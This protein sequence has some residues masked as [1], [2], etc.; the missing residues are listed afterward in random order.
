[1]RPAARSIAALAG[2]AV[3]L[4]A[5]THGNSPSGSA[6]PTPPPTT[7]GDRV[8]L[9][10]FLLPELGRPNC[11]LQPA[12]P[13]RGSVLVYLVRQNFKIPRRDEFVAVRR[14]IRQSERK[15]PLRAALLELLNGPT[16]EERRMGCASIF[17][18]RSADLLRDVAIVDG[19]AV[20]NFRDLRS[21]V[22]GVGA[23][24]ASAVFLL[25]LNLTVLQFPT[26]E[27]IRYELG[28]SCERFFRYLQG[29]CQI[30]RR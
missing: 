9:E 18:K 4:A 30:I 5:C 20:V 16:Q 24:T 17:S 29:S 14:S 13:R 23:T 8:P 21:K 11:D 26:V 7:T 19:Q 28:G 27:S 25:Q 15:A 6:R 10:S 3:L 22:P 2:T 1:M 12:D